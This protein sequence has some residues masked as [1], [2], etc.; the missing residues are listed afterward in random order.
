LVRKAQI[1]V[2][3]PTIATRRFVG[4]SLNDEA[5]VR[6]VVPA[7]TF[8]LHVDLDVLLR[9][10]VDVISPQQNHLVLTRTVH[11]RI[12]EADDCGRLEGEVVPVPDCLSHKR[13]DEQLLSCGTSLNVLLQTT[14]QEIDA[15]IAQLEPEGDLEVAEDVLDVLNGAA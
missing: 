6:A 2:L 9:E 7:L 11:E 4:H 1:A 5:V 12:L 10:V 13:M 15:L 14:I 3:V 8:L